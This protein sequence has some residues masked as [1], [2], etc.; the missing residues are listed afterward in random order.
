MTIADILFTE[1]QKI[2]DKRYDTDICKPSHIISQ[3]DEDIILTITHNGIS[4]SS[5][6]GLQTDIESLIETLYNRTM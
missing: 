6:M 3:M 4:Q 5:K 1:V 2:I